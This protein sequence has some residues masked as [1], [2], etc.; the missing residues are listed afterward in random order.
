MRSTVA[1]DAGTL[2]AVTI[3]ARALDTA[4]VSKG[5]TSL[6]TELMLAPHAHIEVLDDYWQSCESWF[7]GETGQPPLHCSGYVIQTH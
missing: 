5:P 6:M 1:A 3:R 7:C 4:A 2:H